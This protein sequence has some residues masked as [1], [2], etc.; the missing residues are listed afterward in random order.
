VARFTLEELGVIIPE[1]F[2]HL[3][4]WTR[5]FFLKGGAIGVIKIATSKLIH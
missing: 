1:P 3:L 4:S 2:S 5:L